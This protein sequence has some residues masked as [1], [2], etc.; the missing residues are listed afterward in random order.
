M[1]ANQKYSTRI[2]SKR[3]L[4]RASEHIQATSKVLYEIKP[5]YEQALPRV[6]SACEQMI[7]MLSMVESMIDDI[8]E[9]I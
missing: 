5:R 3:Q 9:N 4:T 1:P 6:S 2:H 7:D 8:R